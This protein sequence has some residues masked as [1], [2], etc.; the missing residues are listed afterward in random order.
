MGSWAFLVSVC[1]TKR[2]VP[3]LPEWFEGRK[4]QEPRLRCREVFDGMRPRAQ[5]H[6]TF[7][8]DNAGAQ[9]A[10]CSVFG[11]EVPPV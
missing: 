1:G 2:H 10:P 3:D 4:H 7:P 6:H 8:S 5:T 9:R 11:Q